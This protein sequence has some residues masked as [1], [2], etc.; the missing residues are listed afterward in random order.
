MGR[1]ISLQLITIG[2]QSWTTNVLTGKWEEA[3]LE[4]AYRPDVLFSTQD[5]IGPVMGRVQN[6]SRLRRRRDR[7][8][9]PS[10]ICKPPS[11]SPSSAH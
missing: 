9:D 10:I 7:R 6:V 8:H 5:G 3:P 11:T 4:F 1:A 2:E